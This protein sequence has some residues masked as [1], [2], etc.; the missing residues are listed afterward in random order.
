LLTAPP[1]RI[2]SVPAPELP[3]KRKPELV[4]A[5]PAP[6]TVA[7]PVEP[8]S[9]PRKPMSCTS[10]LARKARPVRLH[11]Y[12]NNRLLHDSPRLI[13]V[14]C[15]IDI[16]LRPRRKGEKPAA[17]SRRRLGQLTHRRHKLAN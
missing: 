3:T 4:Q 10:S 12:Q 17:P 6:S 14:M 16:M 11:E 8:A 1:F 5:E 15:T 7:V 13:L 9:T 2:V